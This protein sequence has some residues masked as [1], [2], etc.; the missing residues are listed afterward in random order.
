[1][2]VGVLVIEDDDTQA[3]NIRL[4]L[5]RRGYDVRT[6][7]SGEAGLREARLFRPDAI[8]L[9]YQLPAGD[10]LETL[11]ELVA[12]DRLVKIVMV[13]AHGSLDIAIEAIRLGAYDYLEKPV[14]LSALEV[15]L[16]KALGHRQLENVVEHYRAI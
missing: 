16:E 7:G 14:P 11:R 10:G 5:E 1:M 9:D 15:S 13:T 3:R 8:L 12:M 2:P 4:F 6:A